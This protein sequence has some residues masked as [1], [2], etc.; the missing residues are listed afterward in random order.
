MNANVP[1]SHPRTREVRDY[2]KAHKKN[3]Q[4]SIKTC[5]WARLFTNLTKNEKV[6]LLSNRLS[7]VF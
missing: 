7:K 1:L 3:I 4:R 5:K 6:E 2:N